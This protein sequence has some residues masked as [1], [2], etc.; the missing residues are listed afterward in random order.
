MWKELINISD[1]YIPSEVKEKEPVG[2]IIYYTTN[3]IINYYSEKELIDHY[4][5]ELNCVGLNGVEIKISDNKKD[6]E[7]H[8]EIL[9]IQYGEFG[10][11][12]IDDEPDLRELG[13]DDL[14]I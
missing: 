8:K 3:E 2:K 6:S 4:K 10:L 13:Y 5:D 14:I 12:Y 11:D 7:L 1:V 9:K